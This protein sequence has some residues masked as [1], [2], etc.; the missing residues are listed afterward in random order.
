MSTIA[1][2][3]SD[4]ETDRIAAIA[5]A[6][7]ES[8]ATVVREAV[9][10]YLDQDAELRAAIQEGIDAADRGELEDF[11]VVA[12]RLRARMTARLGSAAE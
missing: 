12:A 4:E 11:D 3:L 10:N 7:G 2:K 6:R 5:E 9:A 8:A 1:I